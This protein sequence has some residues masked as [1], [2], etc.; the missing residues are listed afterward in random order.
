MIVTI[1]ALLVITVGLLAALVG[2][3]DGILDQMKTSGKSPDRQEE[4]K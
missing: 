2:I 3:M 1:I 4:T